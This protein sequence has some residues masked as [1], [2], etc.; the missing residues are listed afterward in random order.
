VRAR[1]LVPSLQTPEPQLAQK[2]AH[3]SGSG[4]LHVR[5]IIRSLFENCELRIGKDA[6]GW[7]AEAKGPLATVGLLALLALL[8]FRF[9]PVASIGDG[10]KG[11]QTLASEMMGCV[12]QIPVPP[13]AQSPNN[14]TS[15][16]APQVLLPEREGQPL[17]RGE[18]IEGQPTALQAPASRQPSPRGT[19]SQ[20]LKSR[21]QSPANGSKERKSGMRQNEHGQPPNGADSNRKEAHREPPRCGGR[22][23]ADGRPP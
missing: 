14:L 4:G 5:Q 9:P 8:I 13:P 23:S 17:S 10:C 22:N 20:E 6:Q 2:L 11:R 12:Q 16:P 21:G 18:R 15:L 7:R 1:T 3:P 19:P